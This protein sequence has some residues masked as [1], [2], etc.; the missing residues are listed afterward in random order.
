MLSMLVLLPIIAGIVLGLAPIKKAPVAA[1][2]GIFVSLVTLGIGLAIL[3]GFQA[4]SAQLQL[5][6]RFSWIASLGIDY[7]LAVDGL[8]I[9]LVVLTGLLSA[10]AVGYGA[11][12]ITSD[13]KRFMACVLMLE[14]AILGSFLSLDLVL[15]FTFFELTLLPMWVMITTWGGPNRAKAAVKFVAFTFGGSV[16]MLIGIFALAYLHFNTTGRWSFDV[17]DIQGTVANGTLWAKFPEAQSW[18]FWFFAVAFLVKAPCFPL[19]GWISDTY[20]ESPI[21]GP[22]LSSAMV[23]LG[24]YGLLRFCLPLFPEAVKANASLL[25]GLAVVGIVYG[26]MIAAVQK[27]IRRLLAYSTV[28]HM[29]FVLLGIFSLTHI[30]MVGG[31]LQ[32]ISHGVGAALL[33][34]L[35]GYLIKRKGTADLREFGG[36]KA[37]LPILSTMFLIGMLGSVG[38]PGLNGFVGEFLSL[39]GAFQAGYI[40]VVVAAFGVVVAAVYLLYMFQQVFYGPSREEGAA[41]KDLRAPEFVLAGILLALVVIGGLQPNLFTKQTEASLGAVRGMVLEEVNRR[42]VYGKFPAPKPK[43]TMQVVG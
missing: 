2:I 40:H 43:P 11:L 29:G 17:I 24:S 13:L 30:G 41:V 7:H 16:F 1:A 37:S 36:L 42:P 18:I 28:S 38:L 4:D 15:F 31:A 9:W 12:N 20:A 33:F 26:A 23:K 21:V 39:L 3:A 14:G 35:V 22:I 19:H 10:I 32:Q 6:E 25:A 27:D 34:L 5:T 8:S